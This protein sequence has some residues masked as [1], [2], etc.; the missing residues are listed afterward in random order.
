MNERA[1]NI[2]KRANAVGVSISVLCK[3]SGVSR[4]WFENFKVRVPRPV[5]T[6]EKIEKR[7]D[8]LE[9]ITPC[10]RMVS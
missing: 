5:S 6:L 1:A 10:I 3:M 2:Q 4:T 9:K 8:E 7:L